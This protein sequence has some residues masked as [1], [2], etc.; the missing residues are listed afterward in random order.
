MTERLSD[1]SVGNWSH[2][3]YILWQHISKALTSVKLVI[4]AQVCNDWW[5]HS[6]VGA[7]RA[8]GGRLLPFGVQAP[9]ES[10]GS[11]ILIFTS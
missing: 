10:E 8:V 1:V 3:C 2:C 11:F 6:V 4:T 9:P 7:A 5:A